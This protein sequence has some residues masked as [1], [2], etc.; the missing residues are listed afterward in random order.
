MDDLEKRATVVIPHDD[1]AI[2]AVGGTLLQLLGKGWE[3]SYIQM[4]DG[5]HGSTN[6]S[7]EDTKR[8]RAEEI[9]KELKALKIKRR[10]NFDMEDGTLHKLPE[11]QANCLVNC[12]A[13]EITDYKP[14]V[15]F[16]PAENESHPDH[17][18]ASIM[19]HMAFLQTKLPQI[20]EARY[21]VWQLP[22]KEST[23]LPFEK[24]LLVDITNELSSKKRII[25][26]HA[27]QEA[28][29]RDGYA[30]SIELANKLLAR[31]Y[32]NYPPNLKVNAAEVM[33]LSYCNAGS[34]LLE[35]ALKTHDIT[36][37]YHGRK[38]KKIEA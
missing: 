4:T 26:L 15:L 17:K 24:L 31:Q 18:A 12:M 30:G 6:L 5:R 21:V 28:E 34:A 2:I 9:Q 7:Q 16:I 20:C 29:V 37:F 36:K 10:L 35:S 13:E 8:T 27:S 38:D 19:G 22:F 11:K 1:D 32:L 23:V 33:A 25:R 14:S 3:V